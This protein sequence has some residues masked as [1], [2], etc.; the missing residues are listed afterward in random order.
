VQPL[1]NGLTGSGPVLAHRKRCA[2]SS[3][4]LA[5]QSTPVAAMWSGTG[6]VPNG[7]YPHHA[8]EA[9]FPA[10]GSPPI[11]HEAI[12]ASNGVPRGLVRRS[13]AT[14]GL[15]KLSDRR[16]LLVSCTEAEWASMPVWLPGGGGLLR[17]L[18]LR[19]SKSRAVIISCR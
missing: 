11:A 15:V 14:F 5:L 6:E 17:A 10:W 3:V 1:T 2:S 16:E 7:Y 19:G 12:G 4:T 13:L 18:I 9:S 8:I